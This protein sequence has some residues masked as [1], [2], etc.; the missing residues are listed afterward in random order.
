[1][2]SLTASSLALGL[3]SGLIN[4]QNVAYTNPVLPGWHSDP[5]CVFVA[6]LENTTFCTTSSF[7]AFPGNPIYASQDF[8]NWKLASNALSRVEQLPEI[9]I[10]T[11]Q[12]FVGMFANTLRF[13]KGRFYLISAWINTDIPNPRF[14][15]NTATDPFDDASWGDLMLIDPSLRTI[16]PDIFF[17]DDGSIVVASSGAPIIASHLDLITG[18]LSESWTM[19]NGTGGENIEGPHLYKKDG[20]YYLLIAEGGTQLGHSATIA[21]SKNLINGTWKYHQKI[22]WFRTGVQTNTSRL[23]DMRTCLK[24]RTE[25]GGVLRYQQGVAPFYTISQSFPWAEKWYSIPSRGQPENSQ[26]PKKSVGK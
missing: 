3:F 2:P 6:E 18:K 21:R 17:D 7:M 24:T 4:A 8:V 22:L 13:N 5:S 20:Y 19:W 11:N 15:L 23:S 16:D 10:A 9:R 26:S 12:Q 25:T 14:F 1:M